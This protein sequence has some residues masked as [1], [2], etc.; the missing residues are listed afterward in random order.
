[1]VF[2]RETTENESQNNGY[3]CGQQEETYN[4]VAATWADVLNRANL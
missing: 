2:L 4:I 3:K 1:M